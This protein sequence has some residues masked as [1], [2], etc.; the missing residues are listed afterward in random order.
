MTNIPA[1]T[2]SKYG[3]IYRIDN[4]KTISC[5]MPFP[6]IPSESSHSKRQCEHNNYRYGNQIMIILRLSTVVCDFSGKINLLF[7]SGFRERSSSH[8][9]S[10][11]FSVLCLSLKSRIYPS[12]SSHVK[13]DRSPHQPS[14]QRCRAAF[15]K[16]RIVASRYH[17]FAIYV[18]DI[19]THHLAAVHFSK[20]CKHIAD[21]L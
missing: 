10:I 4:E 21:K 7:L 19:I 9:V 18:N 11:T 2:E 5:T 1:A 13:H 14:F 12:F 8:T 17:T 3:G 16:C 6:D 20:R 15:Y